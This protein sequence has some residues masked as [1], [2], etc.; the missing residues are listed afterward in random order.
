MSARMISIIIMFSV[1]WCISASSWA[2][3]PELDGPNVVRFKAPE[4]F[5]EESRFI[6]EGKPIDGMCEF[7]TTLHAKAGETVV[8]HELAYDP[9]T[10]RSLVV[11]GRTQAKKK[12]VHPE[13][14]L[15]DSGPVRTFPQDTA[16]SNDV[17]TSSVFAVHA[18]MRTWYED[19]L[20]IDIN[21]VKSNIWWTPTPTCAFASVV[22]TQ[23]EFWWLT[24]SGWNRETW[25]DNDSVLGCPYVS[26]KAKAHYSNYLFPTC[27]PQVDI[28]YDEN[29]VFGY[30]DKSA[31]GTSVTRKVGK[32]QFCTDWQSEHKELTVDNP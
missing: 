16:Q 4:N 28:F 22:A 18:V 8:E 29:T 31:T 2:Q 5:V 23:G 24:L 11:Q 10:C 30:A 17:Q 1:T 20:G 12:L 14:G 21:E 15:T 32:A 26:L 19:P 25:S 9:D 27:A 13:G 6:R 7:V 3:P